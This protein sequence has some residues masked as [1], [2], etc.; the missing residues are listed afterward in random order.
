MLPSSIQNGRLRWKWSFAMPISRP[1]S[2]VA[3][4]ATPMIF[5]A[6][7]GFISTPTLQEKC[8]SMS[9]GPAAASSLAICQ[10]ALPSH[11]RVSLKT[12]RSVW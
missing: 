12:C 7:A 1:E 6:F 8:R 2:R 3:R 9:P 5:G 11:A 4:C 10:R